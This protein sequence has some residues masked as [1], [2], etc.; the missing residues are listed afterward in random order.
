MNR[1]RTAWGVFALGLAACLVGLAVLA[2]DAGEAL[3]A[4][5]DA[6]GLEAGFVLVLTAFGLVG[7]LVASRVPTNP[8]G[9]LFLA[10]LVIDGFFLSAM[11]YVERSLA[12]AELPG[13]PW[14]A[15]VADWSS[16]LAPSAI[17]L[18]FVL[19]PDGRPATPRWRA[20]VWLCVV[21]TV[22][23]FLHHAVPPGPLDGF[24]ELENPI[25]QGWA[26]PLTGL[27]PDATLAVMWPVAL[28]SLL[29]R[30]RRSRGVERLQLKWFAWSASVMALFVM[31][32]SA[33]TALGPGG[34]PLEGL[35]GGVVFSVLLCAVPIGAGIAILR[36][37]LYDID[38]VINRTLVYGS[39]TAVLGSA[40]LGSVLV[41]Q[42]VLS[43]VTGRSDLA[44]AGSTLAVAALFRPARTTV[45]RLVDRRFYRS[46][47]DA[48]KTVEAFTG[49]LR[50]QLDLRA[51]GEDL[52]GVVVDTVQP[53]HVSVWLRGAP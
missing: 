14:V 19:F 30:F 36:H 13:T 9:W 23:V 42:L 31:V 43:P 8:I 33:A 37:R 20:A 53:A 52:R 26:A 3:A 15:W 7:A 25:G 27:D 47:Y 11:S 39:L 2:G 35:L 12:V 21:G 5:D 44:V 48:Q 10:L 4:R 22:L 49:R 32:G 18:A 17:C 45:Q 6:W 41:L 24:P 28:V 16:S 40:Y 46:R 51:V 34:T 50:S 1:A 38:V 29:A